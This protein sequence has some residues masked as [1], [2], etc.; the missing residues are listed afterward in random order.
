MCQAEVD[1]PISLALNRRHMLAWSGAPTLVSCDL[2]SILAPS[3]ATSCFTWNR[4]T[5]SQSSLQPPWDWIFASPSP[6]IRLLDVLCRLSFR[7]LSC[8]VCGEHCPLPL[9]FQSA[10]SFL[11]MGVSLRGVHAT[12][13]DVCGIK[14]LSHCVQAWFQ[15]HAALKLIRGDRLVAASGQYASVASH[16]DSLS[17][18]PL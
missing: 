8:H 3:C 11:V 4:F 18:C 12:R 7:A 2:P 15:T 13:W 10:S 6:A 1:V 9:I 5:V 17:I 14:P 16:C